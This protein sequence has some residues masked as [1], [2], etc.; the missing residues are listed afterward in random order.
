MLELGLISMRIA[1]GADHAGFQLKGQIGE[2]LSRDGHEVMD[3][4]AHSAL[5]SDYPDYAAAVGRA[6]ASGKAD[7]GILI[8]G[9]GLGMSMAANKVPGIRAAVGVSPVEVRLARSHNDANV[10]TLGARFVKPVEVAPMVDAFLHTAF[11]GGRHAVR[12]N[13]ITEMEQGIKE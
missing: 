8:C 7:R 2:S 3:L 13:K 4:G 9:T 10:L 5:P 1:I 12:V 6:V 11:E